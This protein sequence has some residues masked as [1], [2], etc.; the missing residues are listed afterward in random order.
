MSWTVSLN[1]QNL[2]TATTPQRDLESETG[3]CEVGLHQSIYFQRQERVVEHNAEEQQHMEQQ[4][5]LVVTLCLLGFTRKV[6]V[7]VGVG[8]GVGVWGVQRVERVTLGRERARGGQE[9]QGNAPGLMQ[10]SY[11]SP[12]APRQVIRGGGQSQSWGPCRMVG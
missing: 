7:G 1:L 4:P 11:K 12:V 5:K 6:C 9:W 10:E 3:R 8:V 2:V